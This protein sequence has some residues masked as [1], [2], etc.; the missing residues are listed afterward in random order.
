[1][2]HSLNGSRPRR[3]PAWRLRGFVVAAIGSVAVVPAAHTQ[4]TPPCRQSPCTAAP[5]RAAPT[6]DTLALTLEQAVA[7]ATGQSQEMRLARAEVDLADAQVTAARSAALPQ[8]D[9]SINYTRTFDS[10]FRTSGITVPDSLRFEPDTNASLMERVRY[11]EERA[12]TAGLGGIGSLFGNLPFGQQNAYVAALTGTQTLFAGGRVGAALRIADE[13]RGAARLGLT[14]QVAEIELQTRS[15]YL[16]ALLAQELERIAAAALEQAESFLAQE[17]LRHE[18]GTA[19]ELSVLRADVALENLRPGLVEARN[20]SALATLDLK[21]LVDLP[22]TQPLVLTTPL[23]PPSPAELEEARVAPELLLSQRAAVQAAER[24][25]AIREQQVRIA[26]AAY[27]PSVDLRVNYGRQV[28]PSQI[29][30]FSGQSWRT[31]FTAVVGVSVPVFS[32]FRAQAEVQQARIALDQERLRVAQLRENVQLQYEQALG[33]KQRAAADLAA[34]QRTVDQAQRVHDLTVLRY[35]QG[36]ATQ[37][38]V[39]DARL[40]LLQSRTNLA[41]AIADFYLAEA[42]VSRALGQSSASA[43]TPSGRATPPRVP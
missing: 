27:L 41:Q 12:P 37:L 1:V 15:A 19:S 20:A 25:V 32:G 11:L 24:Q 16:R 40:S 8:L 9:G 18:A 6:G 2:T 3:G 17:R 28:F 26:R 31:D 4:A 42:G 22:L 13:Y 10:P 21:R 23:T 43:P 35:D 30:D 36:L 29:L 39:S 14:E 5:R 7:R 38:E 34:R 33:E